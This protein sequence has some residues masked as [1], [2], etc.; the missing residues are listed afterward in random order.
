[1]IRLYVFDSVS[2]LRE[3]EAKGSVVTDSAPEDEDEERPSVYV[4]PRSSHPGRKIRTCR[5]CGKP[6]HMART[7][8]EAR[9]ASDHEDGD[10]PAPE[11]KPNTV[12]ELKE[13][14][15]ELKADGMTSVEIA[16]ELH[17]TLSLINRYW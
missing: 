13:R 9:K 17:C 11:L 8:P 6:G 2:D 4:T 12:S 15:A 5:N 3:F 1:M 16:K 10:N 7:C 14:I